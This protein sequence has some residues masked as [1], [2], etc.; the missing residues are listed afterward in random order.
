MSV[1]GLIL[2]ILMY[3]SVRTFSDKPNNNNHIQ[4]S[5]AD[6]K[7]FF[8]EINQGY[9]KRGI[10]IEWVCSNDFMYL[11]VIFHKGFP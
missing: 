11:E 7:E 3:I 10:N 6:T 9:F 8:E 5:I 4:Q 2:G 1:I